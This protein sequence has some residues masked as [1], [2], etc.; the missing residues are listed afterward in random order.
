MRLNKIRKHGSLYV[1][2]LLGITLGIVIVLIASSS[3]YYFSFTR[4]LQQKAFESDLS[5]LKHTGHA[6]AITTENAQTVSFQIY[7]NSSIA[8]ILYYSNPHPFDIQGAML[9]LSNYLSSMPFIESIYVY[10]AAQERYYIVSQNGQKGV[11]QAEQ[12]TDTAFME[13]VSDYRSYKPFAPIPR[14]IESDDQTSSGTAVY[15]Y[16]CYDAIRADNKMN[17][18]IAVNIS[19]DWINQGIYLN[20]SNEADQMFLVDNQGVVRSIENLIALDSDSSDAGTLLTLNPDKQ[21]AYSISSFNGTRSLL[22]YTARDQFGWYY[23]RVSPYQQIVGEVQQVGVTTIQI[24]SIILIAGLLLSWLLS[25]YLYVPI[26]KI[27]IRMEDLESEWRNSSYTIRQNTLHKLLQIQGFDPKL[28]LEKLRRVGIQFDFT[29]PYHLI[30]LRIDRFEELKQ[31]GHGDVLTYKFAIMN[32]STEICSKYFR[33]EALDLEDDSL[34]MFVN[35]PEASTVAPDTLGVILKEVQAACK[36]YLRLGLSI[37]VTPL[38]S[39]PYQLHTLYKQAR[40]ASLHRFFEGRGA[41]IDMSKQH[42]EQK[43]HHFPIGKEKRLI[44]ALKT[45][46]QEEAKLLFSEIMEETRAYSIH[47]AQLTVKHLTATLENMVAEIER[48]GSLQLGFGS[49]LHVPRFENVET[50][51]ELTHDFH[52]LFDTIMSK[53]NEKRSGK[54]EE[55]IRKINEIIAQ[56]FANP[57]LSLNYIADELG[58]STYHISRVYRQ[59]NSA[60]II[61]AINDYRMEHAKQLLTNTETS[62]AEISAKTGYT[63]SSYFHRMFKKL[64]GVTPSEFRK[65]NRC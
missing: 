61:D 40:E 15:T 63:S 10:N 6:I 3:V 62:I 34:L 43:P 33:V 21:A 9:D 42:F 26:N 1:K 18:A 55:L 44:E 30:Y 35:V 20:E 5:D 58:M 48:N 59:Q 23:V 31:Q 8:K 32:I 41:I 27:E 19:A 56:E 45:G 12:L 13:I 53:L 46:R 24:A 29:S 7:R 14:I 47:T 4:I 17:S 16:L 52:Q 38:C 28:Q 37:A 64:Y 2:M 39:D 11:I 22:S 25:K 57:M 65:A 50:L 36:E 49:E 51:E 60:T 54:Q